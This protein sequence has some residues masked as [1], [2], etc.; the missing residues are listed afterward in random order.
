MY[1]ELLK[2]MDKE[3]GVV[4]YLD[5]DKEELK[6]RVVTR[7]VCPKCKASYSIEMKMLPKKQGFCDSCDVEHCSK[8]R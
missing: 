7:L 5:V 2:S 4:I 6:N 3:L 1:E 8:G